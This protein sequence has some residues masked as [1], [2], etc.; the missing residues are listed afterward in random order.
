MEENE[1]SFQVIGAIIEVH[2]TLGPG[3]PEGV[4]EDALEVEFCLRGIPYERQ[5][6]MDVRYKGRLLQHKFR[7][8]FLIDGKLIIELKAVEVIVEV[9]EAQLLSYLKLT[10]CKLGILVNF[11]VEKAVDGIYRRALR[12]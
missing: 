5:K 2:R 7:L 10:G 12:L 4:Y 8:D 1:F 6:W 11:N 3:L 9:H